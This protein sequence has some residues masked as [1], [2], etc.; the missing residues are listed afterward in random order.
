MKHPVTILLV[1]TL[2]SAPLLAG[3]E[4]PLP[5]QLGFLDDGQ[6]LTG[7]GDEW[8]KGVDTLAR[9]G[10]TFVGT[11]AK[12]PGSEAR[13]YLES[14]G[15]T[16]RHVTRSDNAD[17]DAASESSLLVLGEPAQKTWAAGTDGL[18]EG[19]ELLWA[20]DGAAEITAWPFDTRGFRL[21]ILLHAGS[22]RNGLV[23][24]PYPGRIGES[25]VEARKRGMGDLV[26]IAAPSID[27]YLLNLEA[28]AA[29][30]RNPQGFDGDAFYRDW[31]SRQFGT[32]A[33]ELAAKS[34]K[35]LHGAHKHVDGFNS[36]MESSLE[37]IAALEQGRT[38]TTEINP[39]NDALN[40]SR[41]SRD[42]ATE[43]AAKVP[44]DRRGAI[45]NGVVQP[46]ALFVH[47][48]DLLESLS[49]L[50][51]AWKIYSALPTEISRQRVESLVGQ[52]HDRS[53]NLGEALGDSSGGIAKAPER[54]AALSA[55]LKTADEAGETDTTAEPE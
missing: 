31:A 49:Q 7:P 36:V 11:T 22:A 44:T 29:A 17:K 52:A 3:E 43:A 41:R 39:V 21:G 46:A 38:V 50:G 19:S 37:I 9:L 24:D 18:P 8:K 48:L 10:F 42:L 35:L 30:Y 16:I 14:M 2:F 13:E 33:A 26:M 40:L 55:R 54:I 45:E 20:D 6:V 5:R 1:L 51:S 27:A 32:E 4:T 28:A 23:Q 34:L 47:N 25:L 12:L 53:V 15:L